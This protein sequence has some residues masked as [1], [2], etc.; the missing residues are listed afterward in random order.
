MRPAGRFGAAEERPSSGDESGESRLEWV[1][2]PRAVYGL[3]EQE[4][5]WV[6]GGMMNMMMWGY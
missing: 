6:R 1:E 5:E 2:A 4:W 3:V